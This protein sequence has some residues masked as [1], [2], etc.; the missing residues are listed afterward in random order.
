M[1][2]NFLFST[3]SIPVLGS[4]KPP[5]QWLSGAF[6]AG[7]KWS[8]READH[9]L[10][11]SAEVKKIWICTFTPPIRFHA[12]VLNYLK[13]MDKFIITL[14]LNLPELFDYQANLFK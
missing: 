7:V 5:I 6:S 4:A 2:K 1:V 3:S 13:H 12:V 14:R 10:P 11:T 8:G 9:S